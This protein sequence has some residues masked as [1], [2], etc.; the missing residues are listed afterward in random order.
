MISLISS[1]VN[2]VVT[3]LDENRH[4]FEDGCYVT[5]TEVKGMEE[6]NSREFK[7]KVLGPYTFSIGDTSAFGKYVSGGIVTEV[8]K[9]K[10]ITFKPIDEANA[11][12]EYFITDFTKWT[13]TI[14]FTSLSKRLASSP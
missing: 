10:Y 4:G 13:T 12:P 8:K 1:D 5:F 6:V 11:N 7:I 2:S 3:T 14:Q 9:P